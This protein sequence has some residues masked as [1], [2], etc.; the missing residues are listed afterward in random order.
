MASGPISAKK[1]TRKATPKAKY[2]SSATGD[3]SIGRRNSSMPALPHLPEAGEKR[4]ATPSEDTP[5]KKL[6]PNLL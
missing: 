2:C 5:N 3:E 6:K 4:P 1:A